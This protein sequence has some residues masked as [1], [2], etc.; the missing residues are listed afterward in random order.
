MSLKE[1]LRRLTGDAGN[2]AADLKQDRISE[3]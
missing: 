2:P 3:L 1:R